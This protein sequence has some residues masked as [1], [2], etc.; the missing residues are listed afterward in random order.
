LN[1]QDLLFEEL[2]FPVALAFLSYMTRKEG[3]LVR[4]SVPKQLYTLAQNPGTQI[5]QYG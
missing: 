2:V 4:V 1:D 5:C 3:A